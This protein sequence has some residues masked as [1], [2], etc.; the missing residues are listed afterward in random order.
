MLHSSG[1]VSGGPSAVRALGYGGTDAVTTPASG[2]GNV[3][4]P[5]RVTMAHP[6]ALHAHV[7]PVSRLVAPKTGRTG[8]AGVGRIDRL[9]ADTQALGFVRDERG[10]LEEGPGVLHPVV[11]AGRAVAL[12]PTAGACRALG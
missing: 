1:A 6:P 2:P 8:L 5:H 3:D 12:R 9:D 4:G 11:F 10:E 7:P